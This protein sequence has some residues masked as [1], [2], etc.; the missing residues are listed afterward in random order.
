MVRLNRIYTKT[1]DDGTTALIGGQRVPKEDL[2]IEAY[3][4]VDETNAWIGM[5]RQANRDSG[6]NADA[7]QRLASPIQQGD[8]DSAVR[9][10]QARFD[11]RH[12]HDRVPR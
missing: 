6:Q 12:I 5:V 4:T 11:A 10:E 2:R 8:G 1:G 3:G 9:L 7:R